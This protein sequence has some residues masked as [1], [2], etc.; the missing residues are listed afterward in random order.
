MTSDIVKVDLNPDVP[1]VN[2]FTFDK[3]KFK[4]IKNEE[5]NPN[6]KDSIDIITYY[7]EFSKVSKIEGL[8]Y[9]IFKVDDDYY[10]QPI[11][12]DNLDPIIN[13]KLVEVNLTLSNNKPYNLAYSKTIIE[14][15]RKEK[16][17]KAAKSSM[18]LWIFSIIAFIIIAITAVF[19][20]AY[21]IIVSITLLYSITAENYIA[22]HGGKFSSSRAFFNSLAGPFYI[23]N[24]YYEVF[25]TYS[26]NIM[27]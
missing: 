6:L 19:L 25:G 15:I 20:T 27:P 21:A 22:A 2:V 16:M 18:L 4:S 3:S 13:D 12:G 17:D 9:M 1:D 10:Y 5:I 8:E 11:S 14:K 24:T 26:L 7:P 23:Y